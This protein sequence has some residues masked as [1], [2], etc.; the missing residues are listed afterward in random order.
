[1]RKILIFTLVLAL[2]SVAGAATY[3]WTGLG[4]D[5][6]WYN[7]AN[8]SVTGSTWTH[9]CEETGKYYTNKDCG[10]INITNGDTVKTGGVSTHLSL[11]DSPVNTATLTI[12]NSSTFN[13]VGSLWGGDTNGT[14]C[15]LNVLNGSRLTTGN[16]LDI[17]NG[18]RSIGNAVISNST[19]N[20]GGEFNIARYDADL[21]TVTVTNSTITTV[22]HLTIC[23]DSTA[24]GKTTGKLYLTNSS[25]SVGGRIYMNDDS[26]QNMY[27]LMEATDST[28]T[29]AGDH[30]INDDSGPNTEA[31]FNMTGGSLT[32]NGFLAVP[33]VGK[34]A[35]AHMTISGGADLTYLGAAGINLGVPTW[36]TLGE[37]RIF[38]DDGRLQGENLVFTL[39]DSMVVYTGGEMWINSANMTE[40]QMLA[41]I[42]TK[43][44]VSGADYWRITTLGGYTGLVPEPATMALLGLGGLALMRR[45]RS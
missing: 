26:G 2:G 19:V 16:F 18:E 28:I 1:M 5:G 31:Y 43:I 9:P 36:G 30:Y 13:V 34:G 39:T 8:W 45:K 12:D 22:G 4:G 40:A 25:L 7:G 32:C 38:L 15:A 20:V 44:D 10:P 37:A 3:D 11:G 24:A 33:Y 42:G 17:A 21:G 6:M 35:K 29:I 27:S 41:L 14:L 23:E